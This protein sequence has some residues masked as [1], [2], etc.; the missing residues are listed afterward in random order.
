MFVRALTYN[1]VP[2]EVAMIDITRAKTQVLPGRNF[3]LHPDAAMA[4]MRLFDP[5]QAS[6]IPRR[7][8][9]W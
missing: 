7:P 9:K 1:M 3:S 5:S 8:I 2:Y 6:D 4:C